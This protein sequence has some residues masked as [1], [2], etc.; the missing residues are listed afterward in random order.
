MVSGGFSVYTDS[1]EHHLPDYQIRT[2]F[3]EET[4]AFQ[5]TWMFS[6]STTFSRSSSTAAAATYYGPAI[7]FASRW[8][9]PTATPPSILMGYC[10]YVSKLID[11]FDTFYARKTNK[12][13]SCSIQQ[14]H[15]WWKEYLTVLQMVQ[16]CLHRPAR[17]ATVLCRLR[18]PNH[19]LPV[20]HFSVDDVLL[21]VQKL[22]FENVW[23]RAAC[24]Q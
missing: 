3:D 16:L 22:S 23:E 6:C 15:L 17:I 11:F 13:V 10:F 21:P 18:L 5:V 20:L 9:A 24:Q 14:T 7:R 8:I 1:N 12:S 2:Q 4:F 19:L